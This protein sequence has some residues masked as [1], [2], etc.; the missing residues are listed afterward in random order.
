MAAVRC[1]LL[2]HRCSRVLNMPG[3]RACAA[4]QNRDHPRWGVHRGEGPRRACQGATRHAAGEQLPSLPLPPPGPQ[5]V[6]EQQSS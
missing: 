6:A 4:M 1:W 5:V 3:W 2:F